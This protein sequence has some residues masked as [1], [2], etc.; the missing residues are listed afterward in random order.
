MRILLSTASFQPEAG[1]PARSV[2]QL[3]A[4]LTEF[5]LDVGLWAPDGSAVTSALLS[6]SRNITLLDGS[7][8]DAWRRFGRVDVVHDNG[9]WRGHHRSLAC[10]ARRARVARVVSPRG[11][12]EPWALDHKP[13]RKRLAWVIY[14]RRLLDSAT[15]LHATADNEAEQLARLGL[16]Q[17]VQI[18]PNG[19]ALPDYGQVMGLRKVPSEKRTCLFLSR[20]H[21]KKGLPL[22]LEAWNELRPS[23]WKLHIAGP[24]EAGHR[25]QL[26]E[27][28]R[29]L[30]LGGAVCFLPPLEGGEKL[31]ALAQADLF[32]LPTY[33]EN[34]GIV[35]AE[36]LAHGCPVVT[37]HGAPWE[38]LTIEEC[39]WW[40]PISTKA[41]TDAL[42]EA[43]MLSDA[44]RWEMGNRGRNLV[45]RRF[46][47]P[48]IARAFCG[49]YE[50]ALTRP[51]VRG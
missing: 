37:T 11:M 33:S 30:D 32:V 17:P 28:V 43:T 20:I 14:Q 25:A 6:E 36:A 22:L 1:G 49:L 10:L 27:M 24:D 3:A 19:V 26:E 15:I 40:V 5:G 8:E 16:R 34:F 42:R 51:V 41:I 47:W 9:I 23:A 48:G 38:E 29:K 45:A 21:P 4:A 12:L 13:V 35:V 18:I 31:R 44:A 39:G 46:S 2:P 7:A 50:E